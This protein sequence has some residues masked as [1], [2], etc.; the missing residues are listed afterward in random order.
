MGKL[1]VQI[2]AAR[3]ATNVGWVFFAPH[4]GHGFASEAVNALAQ[5]LARAGVEEQR[6]YV[7]VGNVDSVRV[8]QRCGFAL[9]SYRVGTEHFRGV[10]YD[11]YAFVRGKPG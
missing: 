8:A 7:T 9:T 1:D 2:N 11:E 4:W 10:A 5:Q 6:A 3:I